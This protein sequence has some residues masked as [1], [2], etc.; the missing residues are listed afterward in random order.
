MYKTKIMENYH[1]GGLKF[2]YYSNIPIINMTLPLSQ[3]PWQYWVLWVLYFHYQ[4]K[5]FANQS[6]CFL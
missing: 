4:I 2:F 6:D 5:D 3:I 1:N